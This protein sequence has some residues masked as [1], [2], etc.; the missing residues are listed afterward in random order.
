MS[1]LV[2]TRL[3]AA[4]L[5]ARPVPTGRVRAVVGLVVHV[6]GLA[7]AVGELVRL[8]SAE[9]EIRSG[10][11]ELVAE[12][13]S[14]SAGSLACMPLGPLRGLRVGDPAVALGHALQVRAGH[15]VLGRVLD[16]LGGGGACSV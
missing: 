6:E 5:A 3:Q 10:S 8:G 14:V 7:A 2:A 1:S 12:V 11:G 16:G 4:V 9:S 15:D 13:V